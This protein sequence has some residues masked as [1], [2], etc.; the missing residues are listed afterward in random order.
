MRRLSPLALLAILSAPAAAQTPPV[1]L[2]EALRTICASTPPGALGQRCAEINSVP[3]GDPYYTAALGQHLDEIPGQGRIATREQRRQPASRS[4]TSDAAQ[5]PA[6]T[7]TTYRTREDG[8][9]ALM[10]ADS[11]APTWSV[12]F[13]ADTGRIERKTGINE[14]GFDANTG[15]LVAGLNWQPSS[16]WLMG[17][18]ANHTRESLDFRGSDGTADTRYTGLLATASRAFG[19][20]WTVDAYIGRL[21]GSYTLDR[22]IHYT[23]GTT[24]ID[25]HALA[26]PDASR[27]LQGI[28]ATRLWYRG[29]WT[30]SITLGADTGR[31]RIEPYQ[32]TGGAGLALSVPGRAVDTQRG[33]AEFTVS[34]AVSRPWGI[35]QPSLRL[36]WRQEFSNER[37]P[38]RVTLI[39]DPLNQPIRFNTEDPDRGWGDIAIG[40]VFTF[41]GGRS[42]FV[43][44]QQRFAHDYLQERIL[45]VGA[46]IEL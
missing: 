18:A 41:T 3:I 8:S 10:V 4:G 28:S 30:H 12:F 36:G 23:V 15:S 26:H 17:L 21:R 31:T 19:D 35:W 27:R 44:Y 38:V 25:S 32:E 42:A 33:L 13:S 22:A 39:G 7:R 20:H 40:S 5:N 24:T 46:R 6:E 45:A 2:A 43:Q 9:Q 34:R 16:N 1:A 14:A 37:R 29:A 11:L